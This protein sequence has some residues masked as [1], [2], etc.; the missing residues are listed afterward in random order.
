MW[1][2][3]ARCQGGSWWWRSAGRPRSDAGDDAGGGQVQRDGEQVLHHDQVGAVEG[4]ASARPASGGVGRVERRD[5]GRGGRPDPRRRRSWS[6]SRAAR[7]SAA[8]SPRR[9]RRRRSRPAGRTG[10][11]RGLGPVSPTPP[12][13][14]L[15]HERAAWPPRSS[16]VRSL[17]SRVEAKPHCGDRQS[18]SRGTNRAASSIRRFERV[19]VLQRSS[20]GGDEAEH[21]PLAGRDEAQ[22]LEAAGAGV[23]VL[24]EEAVHVQLVEQRLGHEVV[25]TLGHPRRAEVAAARV[26][27]DGHALGP[28]GRARR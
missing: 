1:A 17:P 9:R 27:G 25:P 21:D 8:T 16:Y 20:L 28:I 15:H 24:Q 10:R 7:T 4:V 18:W 13:R 11:R 2:K 19:L 26:G 5:R 3:R 14:R 6:G 12:G 23:V 22:R